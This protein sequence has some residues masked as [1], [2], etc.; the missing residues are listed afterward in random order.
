MDQ[1]RL[2]KNAVPSKNLSTGEDGLPGAST[3]SQLPHL[4]KTAE[5]EANG[6]RTENLSQ[7]MELDKLSGQVTLLNLQQVRMKNGV[8]EKKN[9]RSS[10]INCQDFSPQH[11]LKCF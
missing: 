4:L 7:K 11:K 2:T 9:C 1:K 8:K 6:L 3:V 5:E 10:S